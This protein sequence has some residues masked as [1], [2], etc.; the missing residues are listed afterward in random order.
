MLFVLLKKNHNKESNKIDQLTS[1]VSNFPEFFPNKYSLNLPENSRF[2]LKY[3]NF[4]K[5]YF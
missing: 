3:L 4:R 2:H 1:I 5:C